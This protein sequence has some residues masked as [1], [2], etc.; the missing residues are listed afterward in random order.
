MADVDLLPLAPEPEVEPPPGKAPPRIVSVH[1]TLG[2]AL[3]LVVMVLATTIVAGGVALGVRGLHWGALAQGIAVGAA[4]VGSYLVQ[5]ALVAWAAR[6]LGSPFAPAVG[7]VRVRDGGRFFLAAVG[8]ALLA[9]LGAGW[10]AVILQALHVK[11]PGENVDVTRLLPSGPAGAALTFALLVLVA[12]LAEEVVFRGVLL[13][14]LRDRWGDGIAI[15]GSSAVFAAVHVNPF[16]VVPI[17]GLALGLGYLF[18][19]SRSLWVSVACHS[20]FNALGF[21][22]LL[23][24]K[25]NWMA[26][27]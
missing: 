24:V 17:F 25:S 12:P 1:W 19:R 8:V 5:L 4:L 3:V 16:V 15:L 14:A 20:T 22:A 18:V 2:T 21:I 10:Y 11:L 9:R 23:L 7:L 13:S 27:R 6:R 26:A